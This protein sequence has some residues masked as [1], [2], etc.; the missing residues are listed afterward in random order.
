MFHPVAVI[1]F[2]MFCKVLN[3]NSLVRHNSGLPKSQDHAVCTKDH[4]LPYT[5]GSLLRCIAFPMC[6]SRLDVIES[7]GAQSLTSL[8]V[9]ALTK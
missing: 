9:S 6:R 5:W 8:H 3:R 7:A 1:T 4:G 2:K